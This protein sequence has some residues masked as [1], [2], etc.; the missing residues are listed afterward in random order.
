MILRALSSLKAEL[1]GERRSAGR[2]KIEGRPVPESESQPAAPRRSLNPGSDASP[3]QKRKGKR[4]V[5]LSNA[6]PETE[7]G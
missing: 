3:E 4:R 1:A 5:N 7:N 6:W 2:L